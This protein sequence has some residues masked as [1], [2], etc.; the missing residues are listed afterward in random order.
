ME[1]LIGGRMILPKW[2]H[3]PEAKKYFIIVLTTF[4]VASVV[5]GIIGLFFH[6]APATG[7]IQNSYGSSA[8]IVEN[9][10]GVKIPEFEA[11][12][13]NSVVLILVNN[14]IIAAIGLI[15]SMYI[16]NVLPCAIAAVNGFSIGIITGRYSA[17]YS[18]LFVLSNIIPHSLIEI[19]TICLA[20]AGGM[21]YYYH[22][23]EA[24]ASIILKSLVI[25]AAFLLI[26]GIIETFITP[27][28]ATFVG[29]NFGVV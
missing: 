2:T 25:I 1:D 14:M 19:P 16:S 26:A 11:N 17:M 10:T 9:V 4:V 3:D 21:Y 29:I 5:G 15:A 13:A 12:N 24:T 7:V 27:E 18:P 28:I 6:S 20:C 22:K 23:K 8:G